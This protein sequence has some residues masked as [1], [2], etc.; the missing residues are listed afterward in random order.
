M[1]KKM[2]KKGNRP[3]IAFA[4]SLAFVAI[5]SIAIAP[6]AQAEEAIFL[7]EP[8][9][10]NMPKTHIKTD[11]FLWAQDFKDNPALMNLNSP[12]QLI[13][14][15][16][17][18]GSKTDF[19]T[20][21]Y[22]IVLVGGGPPHGF[23]TGFDDEVIYTNS[24]GTDIG[25]AIRLNDMHTMAAVFHYAYENLNGE[26]S[27]FHNWTD[28]T[29]DGNMTGISRRNVDSNL[30][31]ISMLHDITISDAF[32]F[33]LG[34]TYGYGGTTSTYN[35]GATGTG[36]FGIAGTY[37]Q[38]D[39]REYRELTFD[40]HMMSPTLGISATPSDFV[41]IDSSVT[42]NFYLGGVNSVSRLSDDFWLNAGAGLA[43]YSY[44]E[45]I[46]SDDF[47]SW[48]INY[49]LSPEF[50]VNESVSLPFVLDFSYGKKEWSVDGPVSGFFSPFSYLGIYH[51]TGHM[52]YEENMETWDI[53]A[54]GGIKYTIGVTELMA[55]A[56]YT[57]DEYY[58][59]YYQHNDVTIPN[60]AFNPGLTALTRRTNI[61][62]DI[63]SFELGVA[64]EFTPQF[65][66][67]FNIRY[68]M[69]WG[70]MTS[71]DSY[72]S[73]YDYTG[74]ELLV[75]KNDNIMFH[76]MTL[77]NTLTFSPTDNINF[78]LGGNI[79]IPLSP[80]NYN[81]S[82]SNVGVTP[83]RP[84]SSWGGD[85]SGGNSTRTLKYGGMFSIDIEF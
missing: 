42:A 30:Y 84:S 48:D 45:N 13:C 1:N 7:T 5:V 68:D 52:E 14:N 59:A 34:F 74:E 82:G 4:V 12:Y 43:S 18:M 38:E 85:N 47:F 60:G 40:Y 64:S 77:S 15:L 83:G 29:F 58:N 61:K 28:L 53:T 54:G 35:I 17:Y 56:Y 49:N 21:F 16:Y 41:F 50:M 72:T 80:S 66:A 51:G 24:L 67:D 8:N 62:K 78:S 9:L 36:S 63:L 11:T 31:S 65:Y 71:Y 69:G 57:R 27:F 73:T 46:T 3:T 75:N 81:L 2:D 6:L 23:A 10:Y 20:D 37:F 22:N 55:M 33:G 32:S 76:D 44:G 26:G 25:F 70:R 19:S 39:V 79:G